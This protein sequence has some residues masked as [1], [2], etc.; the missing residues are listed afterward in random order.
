MPRVVTIKKIAFKG[1]TK[2]STL[3][4]KTKN[5]TLNKA[6]I[7]TKDSKTNCLYSKISDEES[8]IK[9]LEEIYFA[10]DIKLIL[11]AH[12]STMG[13]STVAT[14]SFNTAFLP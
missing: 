6:L 12:R 7:S 2:Y 5:F 13:T 10:G 4:F 9:M 11:K 14:Y 3:Y 1:Q 8:E